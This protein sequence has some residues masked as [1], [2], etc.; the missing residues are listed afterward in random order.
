M[1]KPVAFITSSG[2]YVE[3]SV[4]EGYAVKGSDRQIPA[5][6]FT[7]SYS[8]ARGL[9][10]PPYVLEALA[11]LPEL[12]TYHGR[13]CC[14]KSQD[15]AGLGWELVPS[16]AVEEKTT[17]DPAQK[18]V[19]EDFFTGLSTPLTETLKQM[20]LDYEATAQGY[21]ELVVDK[22]R[23][24]PLDLYHI[25]SQTVRVHKDRNKVAQIRGSKAVWFKMAGYPMDVDY[26]TGKEAP[27][28]TIPESQLATSV[29]RIMQY[30]SRSD[31]Y[32]IPEWI[33]ALGAIQG[34]AAQR[35]YNL[36]FFKNH[37]I[38]AYAVYVYGDYDLGKYVDHEG[39][40]LPEG[41]PGGE[42]E[43]VTTVKRYFSGGVNP[44]STLVMAVPSRTGEQSVKVEIK[45][46]SIETKEGSFTIY[47]RD[48]R[49]EIMTAHG[50]NPYRVGI[51]E[52]GSLSG[53]TANQADDIYS[54]S[55]LNPRQATIEHLINK[56]IVW[57]GFEAFD[58]RFKLVEVD[59]S[60][61]AHDID[62]VSNLWSLGAMTINEIIRFCGRRFGISESS[63]PLMD[64]HWIAGRPIDVDDEYDPELIAGVKAMQERVFAELKA[65]REERE[66][67]RQTREGLVR[68][69]A[70]AVADGLDQ[71]AS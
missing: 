15:T 16:E 31:H 39:K 4:L 65:A 60:D 59:T 42:Y 67:E 26:K 43:F 2:D 10:S 48:N 25:P 40:E 68:D 52:V 62:M 66:R 58:W 71:G 32:G 53:T 54:E 12:N 45:P 50:V 46:L 23:T 38:P 28:G 47:R 3:A 69:A 61:E 6:S 33:G 1:S 49:D 11:Y 21:V 8:S 57:G 63:H 35:D 13:C 56:H 29:I 27:L 9:V 34:M 41:T 55:I 19:L 30:S 37:G 22:D 17:P 7:G 64:A 14:T 20:C 24:T 51:A 44:H 70:A 5:D 36:S 18:Q